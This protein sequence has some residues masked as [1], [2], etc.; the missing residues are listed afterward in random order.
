[1]LVN[2]FKSLLQKAFKKC[3][4]IYKIYMLFK[5]VKERTMRVKKCFL[6]FLFVLVAKLYLFKDHGRIKTLFIA[7]Y[8]GRT[9]LKTCFTI[10]TVDFC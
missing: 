2:W 8:W 5:M 10:Q 9:K 7:K 4:L 3:T 6:C 1:M